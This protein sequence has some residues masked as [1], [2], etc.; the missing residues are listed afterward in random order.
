[1]FKPVQ[2][3]WL[4]QRW[5]VCL[6]LISGILLLVTLALGPEPA[7]VPV[8]LSPAPV[9]A[10]AVHVQAAADPSPP[11]DAGTRGQP[12]TPSTGQGP[13]APALVGARVRAFA[14][15]GGRH[16]LV[17]EA[18]TDGSGHV[19]LPAPP[20]QYWVLAD[21]AGRARRS[22]ALAFDGRLEPLELALPRAEP[23]EVSVRDA[24]G[25]PVAAATVLVRGD[26]ALPHGARSSALGV[27]RFEHVGP[28][29]ESVRVT[30]AGYDSALVNPASR[31]LVVALST[32][33]AL[34]VLVHTPS[35]EPAIGAEVSLSGI[36][37]WPPRQTLA[38]ADGIARVEGLVRGSYDLRARLGDLVSPPLSGVTLERG[39]RERLTL[40]LTSGRFVSV[41][42]H[43][44][45]GDSAAPVAGAEVT[46]A[47]GGLSPFPLSARTGPDGTSRLGPLSAGSVMLSVRAAGFMPES[48]PLARQGDL[49]VRV[50][51]L[52]GGRVSGRI[53]DSDGNAI[54]GAR[55]EVVGNDVRGRPIARASGTSL[56]AGGFFERSLAAPLPVVP[57]GEL[58]VLAGPLPVPGMPASSLAPRSAWVSD[59]DGNFRLD[60][61][62]PGRVRLL[63]R[64]PDFVE[65][66]SDA[67]SLEPGGTAE[68]RLT[69]SRGASLAGRLLD[70]LGRPVGRARI[71]AVSGRAGAV[72]VLTGPDGVFAF[73]AVP[74]RVDLLVARP[75]QRQRF[76]L[77]RAL[78]LAPGEARELTL[79][80]PPE[81]APLAVV[82]R[83]DDG[84]PLLGASVSL[85]SLAP[86][87]PLRL[88]AETD[89]LGEAQLA[90]AVGIP[91]TL[92][93]LAK[94]YLAF[95]AELDP[96]PTK[97]ELTLSRGVSVA[98]RVTQ[99]GGRQGVDGAEVVLLQDG[100]RRS[101]STDDNGQY[102][103]TSVALGPAT[104]SVRHPALSSET[105]EVVIA[106]GARDDQA[107]E[108]E[109][110]DLVEA[111]VASGRV[112]DA[113]G[114]PVRAARVG[115]GLVPAFVP[116][117]ARLPGFVETDTQGRFELR[118]LPPGEVVLSAYAANV[119]RGSLPGVRVSGD[120]PVTDLEI[121]LTASNVERE[122]SALMNVAVTLGERSAGA[123]LEV[124]IVNVAAGSEA[125]R[126]GVRPGD[127]LWSVDEEVV[128]DMADARQLLGGS[129]GSDVI[130]ELER[131]GDAVF[132]RVRREAVR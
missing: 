12:H 41:H 2:V 11:G 37:F 25:Q 88:N 23:F 64:H 38:G 106:P 4:R 26:D 91:A 115:V 132:V 74:S 27:A 105:W 116:A 87:F 90:D 35:G 117:G 128:A 58:G 53:V 17:A 119:G 127:V 80:L 69:L 49:E 109:P 43:A 124:V 18:L 98:G 57:M 73:R 5:P 96:V 129:E 61:V 118:D 71:D 77:R 100:E 78:T 66:L 6:A 15:A 95:D 55:L 40:E 72:S 111:G 89:A 48:L 44:G 65:M 36:D 92:R 86:E 47:E 8:A 45:E 9:M 107:R 59:L 103:L 104:L 108:L 102:E 30:A 16:V 28:R 50:A 7:P 3:A 54:E 1:M 51:L 97:V 123:E 56:E 63:A 79:T 67:I 93:V 13:R 34:E 10:I 75:E 39:Q 126:A 19:Q 22:E 101:T 21:A 76:V 113:S 114:R 70:E 121:R 32:P 84:R 29:V 60:D 33:A 125:E 81:R 31:Q 82:V 24:A 14:L 85:L 42:V 20:G 52:R 122:P 130:L 131:D 99:A 62:P 112:V 83:A 94:G 110:I 68:L 120:E 46:L